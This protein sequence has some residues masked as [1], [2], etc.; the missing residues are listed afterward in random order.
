MLDAIFFAL[1]QWA[2]FGGYNPKLDD[3][4]DVLVN[5]G[6]GIS[7]SR[8]RYVSFFKYLTIL[9]SISTAICFRAKRENRLFFCLAFDIMIFTRLSAGLAAT[10]GLLFLFDLII[11]GM[12]LYRTLTFPR[13]NNANNLITVFMRDGECRPTFFFFKKKEF[14]EILRLTGVMYFGC[15]KSF[16][17][18]MIVVKYLMWAPRVI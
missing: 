4:Y 11:F 10:W 3:S 8:Y 14:S 9:Y 2:G 15:V 6:C 1:S 12:T 18:L 17:L 5:V 16:F 7:T 13:S